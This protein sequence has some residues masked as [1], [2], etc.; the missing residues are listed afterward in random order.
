MKPWKTGVAALYFLSSAAFAD[1]T[2]LD[3]EFS[4]EG[5]QYYSGEAITL[6][7]NADGV[8]T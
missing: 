3:T 5:S 2:Q 1:I 6:T 4:P 8:N 7:A